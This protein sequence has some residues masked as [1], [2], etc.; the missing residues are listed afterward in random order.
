MSRPGNLR[1]IASWFLMAFLSVAP[2]LSNALDDDQQQ[3]IR[4]SAEEA[5]RDEK[6]GFTVYRGNVRMAQGSLHI[7]A[8]SITI[9]HSQDSADHIIAEGRPAR[10]EQRPDPTKG[11]IHASAQIIEYYQLEERVHLRKSAYIE[12]D[13]ST[14]SGETIDYYMREQRVRADS[15]NSQENSRVEVVIP[16]QQPQQPEADSGTTDG[17]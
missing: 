13:G 10:L 15:N 11:P 4:I 17:K 9:Y 7:E 14:V 2:A 16:A 12:Q 8:D 5:L 6:Q 1:S 3:P